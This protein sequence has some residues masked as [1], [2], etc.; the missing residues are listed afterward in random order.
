MYK[1]ERKQNNFRAF[2]V[3]LISLYIITPRN[4][5]NAKRIISNC[6]DHKKI[7]DI[8]PHLY[9]ICRFVLGNQGSFEIQIPTHIAQTFNAMTA[10]GD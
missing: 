5:W 7:S 6:K 8:G 10:L 1:S 2:Q 3:D 4:L 9:A